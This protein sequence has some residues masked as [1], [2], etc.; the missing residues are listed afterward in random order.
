MLIYQFPF[1][2]Q[3]LMHKLKQVFCSVQLRSQIGANQDSN[4]S[5]LF[6]RHQCTCANERFVDRLTFLVPIFFFSFFFLWSI[7]SHLSVNLFQMKGLHHERCDYT[8]NILKDFIA[9]GDEEA[10]DVVGTSAEE[11]AGNVLI[12]SY[13]FIPS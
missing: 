7:N 13:S 6:S 3:V 11:L 4:G 8:A 9:R 12:L 1:L 5:Q 2:F 10:L